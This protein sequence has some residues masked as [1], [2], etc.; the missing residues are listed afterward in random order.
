MQTR[1]LTLHMHGAMKSSRSGE[2]KLPG[3]IYRAIG[4]VALRV[5]R[6]MPASFRDLIVRNRSYYQV[7]DGTE[8]GDQQGLSIKKWEAMQMPSDLKGKSVIDIG[9]SEGFFSL[10]C[11][12]RGAAP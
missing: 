3:P 8:I 2:Y 12:R 7:F 5:F 9:C 11:A 4:N 1:S 6:F 10:Q